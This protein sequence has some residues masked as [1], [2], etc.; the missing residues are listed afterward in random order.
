ME[1]KGTSLAK[2]GRLLDRGINA[3]L[4]GG[5]ESAAT[6]AAGAAGAAGTNAASHAAAAPAGVPPRSPDRGQ[7]GRINSSLSMASAVSDLALSGLHAMA[8]P[9]MPAAG[10]PFGAAHHRNV[11]SDS[12]M[13]ASPPG[14]YSPY[15]G[16]GGATPASGH[17]PAAGALRADRLSR[18]RHAPDLAL[19]VSGNIH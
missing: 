13:G 8:P 7:L 14:G 4:W 11:S 17:T 9:G 2:I 6:A 10:S 1:R 16:A 3:L 12:V 5:G 19:L 18:R 15:Y